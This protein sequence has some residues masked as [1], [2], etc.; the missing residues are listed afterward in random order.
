MEDSSYQHCAVMTSS[1]VSRR[2]VSNA[3]QDFA[4]KA[5]SFANGYYAAEIIVET[6]QIEPKPFN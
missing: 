5:L 1:I 6:Q 2:S 4:H 3:W